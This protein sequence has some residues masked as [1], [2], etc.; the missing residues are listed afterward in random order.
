L[1]RKESMKW[2]NKNSLRMKEKKKKKEEMIKK[3]K[4]T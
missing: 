2:K 3:K 4:M 1:D